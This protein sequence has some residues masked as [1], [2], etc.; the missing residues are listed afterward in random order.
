MRAAA[1]LAPALI[2]LAA[3]SLVPQTFAQDPC[4]DPPAMQALPAP[5]AAYTHVAVADG[6]WDATSTWSPA[7]VPGDAAIVH[8]PDGFEV[9]V[10][11]QETSRL[12]FIQVEGTLQFSPTDNTRLY[13]DTI[14]VDDYNAG[15]G[16]G[17]F[18]IGDALNPV[19]STKTAEIIF[20]SWDGNSIDLGDDPDEVGRGL[21]AMGKVEVYG[22]PKSHMVYVLNDAEAGDTTITLSSVPGNWAVGDEL[23]LTGSFFRRTTAEHSSQDEVRTISAIAG[24]TITFSSALTYDHVIPA[25]SGF[26]LHLA[27][28]TR[29]VIFRSESG[30]I[31]KRGHIMLMDGRV[32]FHNAALIDLGRT[33][34]QERLDD[35]I[36]N[37]FGTPATD[38][39]LDSNPNPPGNRRGRY[40]LHFHKNYLMNGMSPGSPAPA[41]VSGSVVRNAIGWG[42]VSHSSHVDFDSNIAHDFYGAGFITEMGDEL[43]SFTTN[44][45]IRGRGNAVGGVNDYRP[46][47]IVFENDDRPQPLADFGFSG[48]GFWFQGPALTVVGNVATGCDGTGMMWHT[49][50]APNVFARYESSPGSGRCHVP[51]SFFPRSAATTVYTGFSG[52]GTFTPSNWASGNDNLVIADLPILQMDGFEGYGNLVGFRLRFNNHDSE[53]WYGEPPYDFHNDIP[54]PPVDASDLYYQRVD[55]LQLWNNEGGLS[56]RYVANTHWVNV[57]VVNRLDYTMTYSSSSPSQY[58]H[59]FGAELFFVVDDTTFTDLTI[60]GYELATRQEADTLDASSTGTG[61]VLLYG[62]SAFTN[63]A[64]DKTWMPGPG[65]C[66]VPTVLGVT[67]TGPTTRDLEVDTPNTAI[68]PAVRTPVHV[69][70]LVRYRAAGDQ[71]W[72]YVDA[73]ETANSTILPLTGLTTGVNYTYQVL[74]SCEQVVNG[75]S[76]PALLSYYTSPSANFTH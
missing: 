17:R 9:T 44:I 51:Y 55:N 16:D 57:D 37:E 10:D 41:Q 33:N 69:R 47:R 52:P 35:F 27:N 34:K 59:W 2:A 24:S 20:I 60:D 22:T 8:I 53:A 73:V 30:K 58:P 45:A 21:V 76:K 65:T 50:G 62:S 43:G 4:P 46:I 19:D 75:V 18:L 5:P 31:G 56:Q 61:D 13:V 67:S 28:L 72:Q 3:V 32:A 39:S 68:P 23:V 12:R 38:Y 63:Y 42:F 11:S 49:T 74:G 66:A 36:V 54:G 26:S 29:N 71:Q 70:F 1:R 14:A 15:T 25:G 7:A 64:L 6:D 48:D 40:S